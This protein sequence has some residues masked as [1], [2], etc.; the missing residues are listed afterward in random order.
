MKQNEERTWQHCQLQNTSAKIN[1]NAFKA[2]LQTLINEMH[3]FI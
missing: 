2:A 3:S 1:F